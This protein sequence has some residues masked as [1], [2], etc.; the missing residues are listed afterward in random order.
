LRKFRGRRLCWSVFSALLAQPTLALDEAAPTN[1]DEIVVTARKEREALADVPL[2]I[3]VVSAQELRR[4]GID[5]LQTLSSQVPGLYFESSWGGSNAAPT[6]R[7]QAQPNQ[8]GSNVGVFVDGVYQANNTGVDASMLDLERIE[9]VKGPQSGLYGRSTFSG[10]INYVSKAPT[11]SFHADVSTDVGNHNYRAMTAGL[12]GPLGSSG[13]LGRVSVGIR[14]FDGT[15]VNLADPNENLGGYKKY[16][17]SLALGYQH[18]DWDIAT[19]LRFTE[20]RSEQPAV[21]L[22]GAAD[23]NCGSRN[24]DSGQW[25]YLCGDAPRTTRYDISPGIPDSVTRTLQ[26][27]IHVQRMLGLWTLESLSSFYRSTSDIYQDFDVSSAGR[28]YGVCVA[29][30]NCDTSMGPQII[31]R[32]VDVNQ[33]SFVTTFAE[34]FTQELRARFKSGRFQGMVGAYVV[35]NRTSATD[36]LGAAPGS[37]LL[38][39]ELLTEIDPA[40]PLLV[41]RQSI[42]NRLLVANPDLEQRTVFPIDIQHQHLTD[43]F[44]AADLAL[45]PTL[46]LHGELRAGILRR[47]TATTPRVSIDYHA[48]AGSLMWLSVAEGQNDGGSNNDPTLIPSEQNFGP[49]SN[50]TYE[51]GFRGP[52]NHGLI[53]ID[54]AL[55][56][57]DWRNSQIAEPSNSPNAQGFITRNVSGIETKGAELAAN[58]ALPWNFSA[59]LGYSYD[60]ARFKKGSEDVGGIK[61]CGLEDG[62][63]TSNFCTIGPS[64]A[65]PG[66]AGPLIPYID[67]NLLQ[68]SPRQ[69]WN[70]NITYEPTVIVGGLKWFSRIDVTH[71]GSVYFR[72][73]DG[74]SAGERTLL[75]CRVGI[76]RGE[77]SASLWGSNLTNMTYIRMVDSQGPVFYPVAPR[78]HDLIYGDGRRFGLGVSWH[79]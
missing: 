60:E 54:A 7:G 29:G 75:N 76:S 25:T 74:A 50:W 73:I 57:I 5:D 48:A 43:L 18:F 45:T 13:I 38:P 46:N 1:L 14:A 63:T 10:A 67:G 19:R 71:Q 79:F 6:L 22:L 42:V 24:P 37:A 47:T 58:V 27:S 41:G 16:A 31:S 70:A 52:L 69:Q 55:F 15:G 77:W 49:E 56:Y 20:D 53:H 40:T 33:V 64:R 28:S 12:S 51:L 72:A 34:E 39:N 36:E 65:V 9:V 8:G 2:A 23:Y 35:S 21:A 4:A 66:G 68:R 17:A 78:P 44:G 3:R 26:A 11:Q 30:A 32:T 62:R 61:F 59:A